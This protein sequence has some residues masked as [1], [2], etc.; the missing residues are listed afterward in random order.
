MQPIV[1]EKYRGNRSEGERGAIHITTDKETLMEE[2]SLTCQLQ[3]GRTS[4]HSQTLPKYHHQLDS[5]PMGT[6]QV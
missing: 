2:Y 6:F 3:V 5:E 4:Q 1:A